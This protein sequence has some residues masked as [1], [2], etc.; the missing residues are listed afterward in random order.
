MEAT[1]NITIVVHFRSI[2]H[3]ILKWNFHLTD[4]EISIQ[5]GLRQLTVSVNIPNVYKKTMHGLMVVYGRPKTFIL[6]GF[7]II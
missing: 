5:V 3:D 7:S 1:L 2:L 4:I 6:F